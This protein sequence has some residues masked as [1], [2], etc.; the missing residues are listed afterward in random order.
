MSSE[1]GWGM[2]VVVGPEQFL[3]TTPSSWHLLCFNMGLSS[4]CGHS[5][6][7]ALCQLSIDNGGIPAPPC[8]TSHLSF[9]V[10]NVSCFVTHSIFSPLLTIWCFRP[11][12]I[13][14]PRGATI[15]GCDGFVGDTRNN[16]F[17]AWGSFSLSSHKLL[18]RPL[19]VYTLHRCE[20]DTSHIYTGKGVF[21]Y[22]LWKWNVNLTCSLICIQVTAVT[23]LQLSWKFLTLLHCVLPKQDRYF[24]HFH[25]LS[26]FFKT[27]CTAN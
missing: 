26:V 23:G 24:L 25:L 9:P 11:L 2:G 20:G 7:P 15:L 27:E 17:P 6:N 10:L 1:G 14:F 3:S 12:L 5:L 8:N 16:V 21:E 18:L 22:G 13:F 4:G 19:G